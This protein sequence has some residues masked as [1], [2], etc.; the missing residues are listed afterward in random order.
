MSHQII[1]DA[2][3]CALKSIFGLNLVVASTMPSSPPAVPGWY[4]NSWGLISCDCDW[5]LFLQKYTDDPWAIRDLALKPHEPH[6][7]FGHSAKFPGFDGFVFGPGFRMR[8]CAMPKSRMRLVRLLR[9]VSIEPIYF[10]ATFDNAFKYLPLCEGFQDT[11]SRDEAGRLFNTQLLYYTVDN[12][13]EIYYSGEAA[14]AACEQQPDYGVIC[15]LTS[16]TDAQARRD[17]WPDNY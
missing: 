8:L 9:K 6:A 5:L 4:I 14:E 2:L 3:L 15:I 7:A 11:F 1:L 16:E 17:G 13:G 10:A 12:D